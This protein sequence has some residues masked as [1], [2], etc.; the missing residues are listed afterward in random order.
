M[1][2]HFSGFNPMNI[3]EGGYGITGNVLPGRRK[4]KYGP[5]EPGYKEYITML[6][7]W[8]AEDL[9]DKDFA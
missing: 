9:I 5:L 8:Y 7:K 3:F 1:M 4:V 6:S 2:L